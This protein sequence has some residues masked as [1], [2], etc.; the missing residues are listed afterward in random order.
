MEPPRTGSALVELLRKS[1]LMDGAR[2][3]AYVEGRGPDG[4]AADPRRAARS[5]IRRGLLTQFQAAQLL[6]GKWRGFTLGKYKVL[7]R[8]GTSANSNVYLC[9]HR[10]MKRRVAIKVLT[11]VRAEDPG[12]LARFHREA[13]AAA[14]L[15][16]PNIVHAYDSDREGDLHFIVMEYVDGFSLQEIVTRHGALDFRRA[17]DYVRQAA[18]GLQHIHES[19]LLHRDVKPGNLLLDREGVVRILDLGLARFYHDHKDVLTQKYDSNNILGTADYLSPE[20]ARDSHDVDTR[21]DVYSLGATF[22]FLLSGQPPFEGKTLTQKL[23]GHQ[24]K[25]PAPLREVRPEVPEEL[26]AVVARMMAKDPAQR[27]QTPAEVALVLAAWVGGPVPPPPAEHM[28]RLCPAA[29]AGASADAPRRPVP[30]AAGGGST[31]SLTFADFD[32]RAGRGGSS[33]SIQLAPRPGR[34]PG[35]AAPSPAAETDPVLRRADTQRQLPRTAPR[36]PTPPPA[37]SPYRRWA[38]WAGVV[39]GA[40]GVLT[41]LLALLR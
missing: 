31:P 11:T 19:G 29:Q 15:D 39:V 23:L 40:L 28:P 18:A 26:V 20:Q 41:G 27:Y 14:A 5:L 21:T 3:N 10:L 34:E 35:T 38:V 37:P 25:D 13:R 22:Y 12:A 16:H 4:V 6:R 7:E 36:R 17:A 9:E 33:S 24:T 1:E 30:A 32:R 2:L 8:L